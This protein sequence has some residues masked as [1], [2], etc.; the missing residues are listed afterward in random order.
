MNGCSST[1]QI[2]LKMNDGLGL[3]QA[4]RKNR[5]AQYLES[6]AEKGCLEAI[7]PEQIAKFA[8]LK[9]RIAYVREA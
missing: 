8:L 7:V 1:G 3:K 4:Y 5:S 9:K 6:K 2:Y